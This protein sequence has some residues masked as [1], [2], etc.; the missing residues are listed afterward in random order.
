MPITMLLGA[1][2]LTK[3]VF[4]QMHMGVSVRLTLFS[5]SQAQASS[6]AARAF[7]RFRDLD[8]LMSD[9]QNASELS[10]LNRS[11]GQLFRVSDDVMQ[12]LVK[13]RT[14]SIETD[15]MFD[16]TVGPSVKLWRLARS[17]RQLPTDQE[18]AQARSFVGMQHVFLMPAAYQVRLL[19]PTVRLDLGGIA[20]GYACEQAVRQ[21]QLAG[22]QSAMIEAGGDIFVSAAPPFERGWKIAIEGTK[23]TV[24]V[25]HSAVS[26]SGSTVQFVEIGG[27]R[28]SHIVDPRTGVGLRTLRQV[29]TIGK[30]GAMVDAL[31]TA[32]CIEPSLQKRFR[33]VRV[34]IT[35]RRELSSDESSTLR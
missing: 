7:T 25:I 30:D 34:F 35:E 8:S 24:E 22:V 12:V 17:S 6:A 29:T 15:G 5:T 19:N 20:K 11:Q 21:T 1:G 10:Q 32:F 14:L 9:Y 3:F 16:I 13:A 4:S 26:T 18:I 31:A 2:V 33:G 23:R 28:Y 27:A